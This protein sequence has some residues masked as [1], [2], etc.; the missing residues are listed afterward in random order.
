MTTRNT[1]TARIVMYDRTTTLDLPDTTTTRE[2]FLAG[3][4]RGNGPR[5]GDR[6]GWAVVEVDDDE[7][8]DVAVCPDRK[9]ALQLLDRRRR[10]P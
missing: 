10:R 4:I 2:P 1:P 7:T 9:D 3:V 5:E 8:I 6:M